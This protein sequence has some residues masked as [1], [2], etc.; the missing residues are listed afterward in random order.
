MELRQ[1]QL[2]ATPA[3]GY[4][5]KLGAAPSSSSTTTTGERRVVVDQLKPRGPA[6]LGGLRPG[7]VVVGI[8]GQQVMWSTLQAV[9]TST[10]RIAGDPVEW[11]VWRAREPAREG[12]PAWCWA[13]FAR[14]LL[15]AA[16]ERQRQCVWPQAQ[17]RLYPPAAPHTDL[18]A[19]TCAT[20]R[21]VAALQQEASWQ[22]DDAP[23]SWIWCWRQFARA[24]LSASRHR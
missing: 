12:S 18:R 8:G 10:R 20:A 13:E 11:A 23:G 14:R 7:D 24:V 5:V 15:I 2:V 19:C 3:G 17:S 16:R 9:L 22:P 6:E 1:V 21:M 4:G